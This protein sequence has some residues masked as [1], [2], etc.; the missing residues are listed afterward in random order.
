LHWPYQG[1]VVASENS[2]RACWH[3]DGYTTIQEFI[4]CVDAE[5]FVA[6]KRSDWDVEF[7]LG[8]LG[9]IS[10]FDDTRNGA[11]VGVS[12]DGVLSWGEKSCCRHDDGD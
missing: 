10:E 6:L 7:D 3:L 2:Q 8:E 9:T 4:G 12:G 1:V 11:G 5:V